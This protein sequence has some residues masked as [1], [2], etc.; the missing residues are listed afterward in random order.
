[1]HSPSLDTR[2]E[3]EM[4]A[5]QEHLVSNCR[6]GAR[7]GAQDTDTPGELSEPGPEQIGVGY[8]CCCPTCQPA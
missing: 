7:M 6:M 3:A 8:L 1:M 2:G 5:I 4:R